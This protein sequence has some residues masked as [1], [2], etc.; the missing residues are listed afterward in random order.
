MNPARTLGPDIVA[1]N[2][3]AYWVYAVGPLLGMA[4]AVL[5]AFVLRGRG[6]GRDGSS[7]AQGSTY[8]SPQHPEKL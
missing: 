1:N 5:A 7:A 6:G 4:L 3:T 2:Y 8:T